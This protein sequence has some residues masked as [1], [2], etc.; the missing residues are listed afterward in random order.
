MNPTSKNVHLVG[1]SS[2]DAEVL[3]ADRPVIVDFTATWC[4]PCKFLGKIVE[5]I[6]DEHVGRL[7]VVVID[8]DDAPEIAARYGVRAV[9]TLMVFDRGEKVAQRLG[10]TTKEKLLEMVGDR[11]DRPRALSA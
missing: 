5:R 7:K 4:G 9:P 11:A 8:I 10:V 3:Q 6:A 1:T 2:F